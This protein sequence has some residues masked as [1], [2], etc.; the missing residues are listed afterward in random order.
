LPEKSTGPLGATRLNVRIVSQQ[1]TGLSLQIFRV[2]RALLIPRATLWITVPHRFST[3]R[4]T[5]CVKIASEVPHV[6]A[7]MGIIV[8]SV[9]LGIDAAGVSPTL[10]E[11]GLGLIHRP[12][13]PP[14]TEDCTGH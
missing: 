3:V 4:P 12:F 5:Q 9:V 6:S 1:F 14:G 8:L 2:K 11:G 7:A 13:R 10:R